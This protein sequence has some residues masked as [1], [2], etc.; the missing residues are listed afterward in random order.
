MYTKLINKLKYL[1]FKYKAD[2]NC[3]KKVDCINK[4]AFDKAAEY[5]KKERKYI[6]KTEIYKG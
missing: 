4:Q 1:C 2:R 3:A 5:R 6:E